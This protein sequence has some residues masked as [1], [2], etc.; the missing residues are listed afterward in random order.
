M[1]LVIKEIIP[2]GSFLV[3]TPVGR[4]PETFTK[5]RLHRLAKTANAMIENGLKIPVPFDHSKDAVPIVKNA[6]PASSFTNAGYWDRMVVGENEE[7]KPVLQ[8]ITDLPG[9]DEEPDSPYYKAKN[10]AKEVSASI[11]DEYVDGLGRVW[12][13]A[14]MHVAIVN[15]AVIPGQKGFEDLPENSYVVNMSM[16]DTG[17]DG[18]LA[19]MGQIK[20]AMKESFDITLPDTMDVR[21]FLRDLLTATLNAKSNQINNIEPVP[22]FMS[23]GDESV[24]TKEQAEAIVAAKTVNAKTGKP[25]TMEELGFKPAPPQN[26]TADLSALQAQ[27]AEK[28]EKI[29]KATRL[30]QALAK[31]LSTE[32]T[33][34][35]TKRIQSLVDRGIITKDY[36]DNQLTPKI[37]FEM[38]I[39]SKTNDFADHP[40]EATLSIL[41]NLPSN[42]AP[43]SDANNL[44]ESGMLFIQPP[45]QGDGPDLNGKDL[46][47]ALEEMS[48]LVDL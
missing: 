29:N 12:K 40:L 34:V 10:S 16:L 42:K 30:L 19:L 3:S 43:T 9:S 36:A 24:L 41:E 5:E 33:N 26:T 4:K 37:G 47:E 46:D 44:L 48:K 39:D 20:A 45:L 31:K 18:D 22:I 11:R 25:F 1:P 14:I 17:D 15:H 13:D 7:G 27:L 8:G 38:S 21:L 35:I 28:D 32:T 2:E 23:T 6:K